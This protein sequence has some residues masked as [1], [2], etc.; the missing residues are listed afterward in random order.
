[1]DCLMALATAGRT[2]ECV[3][4]PACGR[5]IW[6]RHLSRL[7]RGEVEVADVYRV[8]RGI[9]GAK[10]RRGGS[11]T[12]GWER[13]WRTVGETP[14]DVQP[15]LRSLGLRVIRNLIDYGWLT[16]KQLLQLPEVKAAVEAGSSVRASTLVAAVTAPA[17]SS[18]P[19]YPGLPFEVGERTKGTW[20]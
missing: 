1:M 3:S 2:A 8:L 16:E 5:P 9:A 7:L 19:K 20:R 14:A 13:T 18:P 17:P 15:R 12:A 6:A 4:C 10:G 11:P